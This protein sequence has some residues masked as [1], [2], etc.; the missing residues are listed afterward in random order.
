MK[1]G[2]YVRW[3]ANRNIQKKLI[4]IKVNTSILCFSH[5]INENTEHDHLSSPYSC[6]SGLDNQKLQLTE[7]VV[8]VSH[9][10]KQSSQTWWLKQ[11]K[12]ITLQV[13]R[14]IVLK[15]YLGGLCS[16]LNLHGGIIPLPFPD[17][18]G[19]LNSWFMAPFCLQNQQCR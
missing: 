15:C 12:C 8:L 16:F 11:S 19:S 2:L 7:V 5:L 6:K 10:C 3:K 17:S 4:V 1:F 9:C 13:W 14:S 18:R